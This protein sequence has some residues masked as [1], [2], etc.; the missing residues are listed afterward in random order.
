MGNLVIY[1]ENQLEI[2]SKTKYYKKLG[3]NAILINPFVK[4]DEEIIKKV[5]KINDILLREDI[6]LMVNIDVKNISTLL[7]DLDSKINWDNPKIRKA[8]YQFINYLKKYNLRGFYFTNFEKLFAANP[9]FYIRELSKN[10]LGDENLVSIGEVDTD[11]FAYQKYLASDEY[12]NFSYIYNRSL[13]TPME[14]LLSAKKY[15]SAIHSE[16]VREV[17]STDNVLASFTNNENFPFLTRTLLAGVNLFLR[18]GFLLK[19]FE[20]LGIFDSSTY[21]NDYKVLDKTNKTSDFYQKLIKIKNNNKAIIQG[22]YRE[23]FNRDPDIFAFVRTYENQK[24]IVFANFT[25]KEILADIRFHFIDINDFTYLIGNYGRRR[26]VKNLL[27]R[28]YEFVTF[29]K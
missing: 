28:P 25:Q 5:L 1:K 9:S 12:S 20:E 29:V 13:E 27:L 14:N 18:G 2:I 4:V 22:T 21:T 23:I 8:F 17:Y 19:N 11:D 16:N 7:L 26:I 15:I 6:R 10:T 24:V 3:I